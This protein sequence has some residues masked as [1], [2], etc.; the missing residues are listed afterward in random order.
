M[1]RPILEAASALTA[2]VARLIF[3]TEDLGSVT[4]ALSD[5]DAR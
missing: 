3:G 5:M 1:H 2:A 4:D